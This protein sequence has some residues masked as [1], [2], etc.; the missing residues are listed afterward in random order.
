MRWEIGSLIDT[1]EE[2]VRHY[3]VFSGG[4]KVGNLCNA[5]KYSVN[6][7]DNQQIPQHVTVN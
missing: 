3:E 5:E 2:R 4:I 6:R 1:R 7:G